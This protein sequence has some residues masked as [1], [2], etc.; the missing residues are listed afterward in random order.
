MG[1]N[2]LIRAYSFS[3]TEATEASLVV[4]SVSVYRQTCVLTVLCLWDFD[5]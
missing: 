1:S 2:D 3:D 4:S 5:S